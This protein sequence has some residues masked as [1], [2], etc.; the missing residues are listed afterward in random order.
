MRA[1]FVQDADFGD[2]MANKADM[3][4]P[5]WSLRFMGRCALANGI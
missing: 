1:F 3:S 5:Q 4:L 2:I